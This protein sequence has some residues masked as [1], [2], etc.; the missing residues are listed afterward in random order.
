MAFDDWRVKKQSK[1]LGEP[2]ARSAEKS[3][4]LIAAGGAPILQANSP[5]FMNWAYLG[6]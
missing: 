2:M 6:F 4:S 3:S 5:D 1:G